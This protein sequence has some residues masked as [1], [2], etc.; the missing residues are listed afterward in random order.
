MRPGDL[1]RLSAARARSSLGRGVLATLG[2][3]LGAALLVSLLGLVWGIRDE[4][5]AS[6]IWLATPGQLLVSM[7]SQP[8]HD[9]DVIRLARLDGVLDVLPVLPLSVDLERG[10]RRVVGGVAG[11]GYAAHGVTG[12]RALAGRPLGPDQLNGV[13]LSRQASE[14]LGFGTPAEAI[15]QDILARGQSPG[16]DQSLVIVG[17][18]ADLGRQNAVVGLPLAL[19]VLA[20]PEGATL[21]LGGRLASR[22]LVGADVAGMNPVAYPVAMVVPTSA[23]DVPP[24]AERLRGAGY[25]LVD[26][27]ALPEGLDRVFHMVELGLLGL[28]V[29]ASLGAALGV[30][31]TLAS[32]AAERTAEVGVLKALGATDWQVLLLVLTEALGFGLAGGVLGALAGW[33]GAVGLSVGIGLLIGPIPTPHVSATL[34][35]GAVIVAATLA[36]VAASVP[37]RHAW[38]LMPA[39]AL[40]QA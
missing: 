1:I 39:D 18:A 36:L 34:L 15:G 37:A 24:L 26:A 20:G 10:E 29:I 2:L 27:G 17:V 23:A 8:L 32:R 28:G 5:E 13:V 40:R 11:V 31:Q 25:E 4:A 9:G 7:H 30:V 21:A 22:L 16:R 38:R 3:A 33:A 14:A 19:D 35:I 6:A 12:Y